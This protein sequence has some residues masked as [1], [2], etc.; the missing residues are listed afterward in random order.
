MDRSDAQVP[1]PWVGTLIPVALGALAG[2]GAGVLLGRTVLRPKSLPAAT[3][4]AA[5]AG[6]MEAL[7]SD[8]TV[9]APK[10]H[11]KVFPGQASAF[12]HEADILAVSGIH[13]LG[14]DGPS[15]P[16]ITSRP[17][18]RH[19]VAPPGRTRPTVD[20]LLASC[21]TRA[22]M[23]GIRS[24]VDMSFD[25]AP[26]T[27]T[28][29]V[30]GDESSEMLAA[31]NAFRLMKLIRFDAPMPLL[32]TTNLYDWWVARGTAVQFTSDDNYSHADSDRNRIFVR[33]EVLRN[34]GRSWDSG[35][36]YVGMAAVIGLL[37]HEAWHIAGATLHTTTC[38]GHPE[39]GD[40]P[41]LAYGGAWAAQYWYFRWLAEHS[42]G[43]LTPSQ[44]AQASSVA[45]LVSERICAFPR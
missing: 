17:A 27:W 14:K 1:S 18:H 20:S 12:D 9:D 6:L 38:A 8:G 42:G 26:A 32:N 28:C 15:P 24:R 13:L 36:T 41:S 5:G 2:L 37:V 33:A 3:R 39:G 7:G 40:D 11:D 30:G 25:V 43:H 21:P 31:Y 16:V 4:F 23:E 29:S 35:A 34:A 44:K 22:E 10:F 45:A 19:R